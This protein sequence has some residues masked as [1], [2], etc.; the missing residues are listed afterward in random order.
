MQALLQKSGLG[1]LSENELA[2]CWTLVKIDP[3]LP[4]SGVN[5][6]WRPRSRDVLPPA[7]PSPPPP[8]PV[9]VHACI[10]VAPKGFDEL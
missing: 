1:G 2:R 4:L 7:S 10:P 5:A 6:T 8:A 3:S 9:Y